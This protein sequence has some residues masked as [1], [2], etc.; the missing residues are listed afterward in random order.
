[1]EQ[2]DNMHKGPWLK[3]LNNTHMCTYTH[4]MNKYTHKQTF[5]V[6]MI[7]NNTDIY[8][9]YVQRNISLKSIQ[10]KNLPMNRTHGTKSTSN[11]EFS[12]CLT[13]K[14]YF[15]EVYFLYFVY[16]G[17]PISIYYIDLFDKKKCTFLVQKVQLSN[18]VSY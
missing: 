11:V 13:Y 7:Y 14:T 6:Y 12:K 4:A 1:M 5:I 15:E 8:V 3:G 17:P 18:N 16:Q 10:D 9:L 2:T